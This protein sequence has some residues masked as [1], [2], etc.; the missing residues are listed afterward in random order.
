MTRIRSGCYLRYSSR[1]LSARAEVF[2]RTVTFLMLSTFGGMLPTP[3]AWAAPLDD[4]NQYAERCAAELGAGAGAYIP[5][6]QLPGPPNFSD[7]VEVPVYWNQLP[8]TYQQTGATAGVGRYLFGGLPGKKRNMPGEPG[9]DNT[10]ADEP[11]Y[12][13]GANTIGNITTKSNLKCDFWSHVNA[14][15]GCVPGQRV[16]QKKIGTCEGNTATNG[17]ACPSDDA[18]CGA[19]GACKEVV[20]WAFIFRRA[21]P[22][23]TGA[24][25]GEFHPY[26]FNNLDAVAYKADTG[27]TCWFDTIQVV[28]G[29][30]PRAAKLSTT[31]DRWWEP[32]TVGVPAGIPRAG[33]KDR[34]KQNQAKTFWNA[35]NEIKDAIALNGSSAPGEHCTGCHGNGPV[36]V[37]RWVNAG[38]ALS[39]SEKPFWHPAKLLP[40]PEFKNFDTPTAK[41]ASH[42]GGSCHGV[43]SVS[44]STTPNGRLAEEMTRDL[45]LMPALASNYRRQINDA[46]GLPKQGKCVGGANDTMNCAAQTECPAGA[47]M[48]GQQAG[49]LREMPHPFTLQAPNRMRVPGTPKDWEDTVRSGYDAM[50]VCRR[51][52]VGGGRPGAPCAENSECPGSTCRAI[53]PTSCNETKLATIPK[54]FGAQNRAMS[55]PP[56]EQRIAPPLPAEA[57]KVTRINCLIA[58]NGEETCDYKAEWKDILP[59]AGNFRKNQSD[60]F[61]ADQYFLQTASV[62]AGQKPSTKDYC[63]D[64]NTKVSATLTDRPGSNWAKSY[65]ASSKIAACQDIQLRL[66]GG[67]AFD[68]PLGAIN[69]HSPVDS[70]DPGQVE[71]AMTACANKVQ[72]KRSGYRLNLASRRYVQTVTLT[73][74]DTQAAPAPVTFLMLNLSNNATLANG[75][76]TTSAIQPTGTPYVR[77]GNNALGPGQTVSVRL[78]F[79]N[80][81]NKGITYEAR[82]RT[83]PGD[84]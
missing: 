47:C 26:F 21:Q 6:G 40:N 49:I 5:I 8:I 50:S 29:P 71:N 14:A 27:G 70:R 44:A 33:G 79:S 84:L 51:T 72:I 25:W 65:V 32:A 78:E 23:V 60:Y 75:S 1:I 41:P 19:G 62:A 55:S 11:G 15:N 80:P 3:N 34:D 10:K 57:F 63:A 9:Y 76:G 38:R 20:T 4:V 73:N 16:L 37:S 24:P 68:A 13:D 42:C 52:C 31:K 59:T 2:K 12:P 58:A 66:C 61:S 64:T 43:W 46:T 83:G 48:G 74:T 18:V 53:D 17:M 7:T 67:Y 77:A 22:P 35:P 36:L 39:R 69:S 28:P 81:T 54:F 30:A 82:V 45:S 56:T